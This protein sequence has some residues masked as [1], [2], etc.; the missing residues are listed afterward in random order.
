M[1]PPDDS[2]TPDD[3]TITFN[4]S[5][6]TT[7]LKEAIMIFG[8]TLAEPASIT[9]PAPRPDEETAPETMVYTDGAC[10]NNGKEN[11]S[12]G[13]GVWYDDKDPRN[14]CVR[15]PLQE[16]SN[17]TG[18]LFAILLAVRNHPPNKDLTIVSDSKYAIDGLTKNAMGGQRLD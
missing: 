13:S 12:A 1:P 18:E 7:E 4:T 3:S 8:E 11:A 15:V 10:D 6:Y 9:K 17:Q 14:Q 16:Q 2:R 5:N